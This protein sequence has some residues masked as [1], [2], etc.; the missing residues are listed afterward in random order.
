MKFQQVKD[1]LLQQMADGHLKAG[2]VLPPERVLAKQLGRA[3]HTVRHALDELSN[4]QVVQRV[5]GKGTLIKGTQPLETKQKLDVFA[6]IVPNGEGCLYPSLIRGVIE[7]AA[8][9]HGQVLVCNT[10]LDMGVQSDIILQLLNKKNL[11]GVGIVPPVDPMPAYQLDAL[12]SRG[13]PVV[14][15]HRRPVGLQAP[16]ITWPFEEVGR[17]AGKAIVGL[18]HRRVAF[19]ATGRYVVSETYLK[20]LREILGQHGLDLPDSQILYHP[21]FAAPPSD[22]EVHRALVERLGAS[23]RPTAVFCSDAGQAELVFYEAG[24]LGLRVPEDLSIVGFGCAHREGVL[25]KRIATVTVDEVEMGR[26]VVAMLEQ[27][28]AGE[29]SRDGEDTIFLPLG[30]SECQTLAAA[31]SEKG[32]AALFRSGER[33]GGKRAGAFDVRRG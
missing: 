33:A 16:L 12:R 24:R 15:C 7:A 10:H 31:P 8:K 18:G 30:F 27:M 14:F 11:G 6:L 19:M 9:S 2:D 32:D 23:D 29:R 1:Y 25:S 17:R 4:E 22:N 28:Q 5:R 20:G 13:I 26:R 3:V 21:Q